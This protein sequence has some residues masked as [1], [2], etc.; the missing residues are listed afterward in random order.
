[1]L[2]KF[3]KYL[4]DGKQPKGDAK[5]DQEMEAKEEEEKNDPRMD[6]V[7]E[8]VEAVKKTLSIDL[9]TSNGIF[10]SDCRDKKLKNTLSWSTN[11][12]VKMHHTLK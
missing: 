7:N 3:Y 1:M 4:E 8:I 9:D 10:V 11:L 2:K 5:D 6:K 12:F